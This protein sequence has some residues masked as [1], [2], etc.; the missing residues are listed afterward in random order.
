VLYGQKAALECDPG[1]LSL[2][3]TAKAK[4]TLSP[5]AS[6]PWFSINSF[7]TCLS[8]EAPSFP[9]PVLFVLHDVCSLLAF[10]SWVG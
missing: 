2:L 6:M 3:K 1:K 7:V 8:A 5:M 4:S 10:V 9:A